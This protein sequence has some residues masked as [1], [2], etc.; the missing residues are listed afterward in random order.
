MGPAGPPRAISVSLY[1]D[2]SGY[3]D[4]QL[5]ENITT[6]K[7]RGPIRATSTISSRYA[8]SDSAAMQLKVADRGRQRGLYQCTE[9]TKK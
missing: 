7:H 1:F 6:Q 3:H 4:H 5:D 9:V 2:I 8:M